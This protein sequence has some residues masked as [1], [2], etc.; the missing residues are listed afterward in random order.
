VGDETYDG[1]G[2]GIVASAGLDADVTVLDDVDTADTVELA[3]SVK[4]NEKLKAVGDLLALSGQLDGDTLLEVDLDVLWGGRCLHWVIS[5]VEVS[6]CV[7]LRLLTAE[8]SEEC[9]H[10]VHISVGGGLE[11]SSS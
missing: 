2:W 5:A 8:L 6:N 1:H 9:T 10:R 7:L 3:N 11:G 4:S